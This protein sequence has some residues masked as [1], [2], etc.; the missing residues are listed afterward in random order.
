MCA[1]GPVRSGTGRRSGER[2]SF[3]IPPPPKFLAFKH[4]WR[5]KP[6]PFGS[7][8]RPRAGKGAEGGGNCAEV[9]PLRVPSAPPPPARSP[10]ALGALPAPR[11]KAAHRPA[12]PSASRP[13][14]LP[15]IPSA[16]GESFFMTLLIVNIALL[17]LFISTLIYRSSYF[18]FHLLARDA[19]PA[20]L[21]PPAPS[22]ARS[23]PRNPTR[24]PPR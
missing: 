7:R 1:W 2:N 14:A 8:P 19:Q 12:H 18:A 21:S 11:L 9:E 20:A 3:I 10:L 13:P 6:K 5:T 15:V 16:W 24:G 23:V 4:K 22:P 17:L